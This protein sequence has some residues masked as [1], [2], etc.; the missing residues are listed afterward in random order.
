MPSPTTSVVVPSYQHGRFLLECVTSALD[1]GADEVVV[2]DDGSTDDSLTRLET[3]QSESRLVVI[4]QENRGADV[5]IARG[6]DVARGEVA[7]ILNSDDAFVRG[8]IPRLR[9]LFA[10]RPELA[11][12]ASWI[13]VVDS[14]GR[15]LAVKEA[16]RNLPPWPRPGRGPGLADTGD[17]QLALLE[18]NYVAT[19]SNLACRRTLVAGGAVELQPLRYAHDWDL[20]LALLE[21]GE[22]AVVPEPLVRYRVH[23]E[24]TIGEGSDAGQGRMRF[25]IEWVVARWARRVLA[26]RGDGVAGLT[27]RF[28]ASAPRFGGDALLAQLLALRGETTRPPAAYDALVDPAHPLHAAWTRRLANE[29]AP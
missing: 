19:T 3:L 12:A 10:T 1:D 4:A 16:W 17:P 24:N 22:M 14:D 9:E 29:A 2:V 23:G 25:E 8:R 18:S 11:V 27:A 21:H 28:W 5:A 7:F 15:R 6:L 20:V 26:R 13:E